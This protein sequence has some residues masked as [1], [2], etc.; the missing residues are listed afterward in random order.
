MLDEKL[1]L[2]KQ[3][4]CDHEYRDEYYM[5][6]PPKLMWTA[7]IKCFKEKDKEEK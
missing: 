2:E 4:N 5:T 1:F 7:C 3:L 6:N